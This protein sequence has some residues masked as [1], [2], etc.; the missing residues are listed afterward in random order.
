MVIAMKHS[1]FRVHNVM[2]FTLVELLVVMVVIAI[3]TAMLLPALSK[4]REFAR[5]TACLNITRQI[6]LANIMYANSANSFWTPPTNGVLWPNNPI[7][8]ENLGVKDSLPSYYWQSGLICPNATLAWETTKETSAGK[9]YLSYH[10]YG[11]TYDKDNAPT[12]GINLRQVKRPSERISVCDA[13]DWIVYHSRIEPSS[14]YWLY[15]E[16]YSSEVKLMPCYRHGNGQKI[17]TGFYDGHAT[18]STWNTL[19]DI[20][21]WMP[22]K[23]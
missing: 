19:Q 21:I 4:S 10:S 14:N 18:S 1:R 12:Y 22:L 6:G 7:F 13:N 15:G 16:T 5:E 8:M 2:S 11:V 20:N 23:N 17:V 9:A 3:L